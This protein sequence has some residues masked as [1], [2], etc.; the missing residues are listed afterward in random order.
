MSRTSSILP[1]SIERKS[2]RGD[3]PPGADEAAPGR[4]QKPR[5]EHRRGTSNRRSAGFYAQLSRKPVDGVRAFIPSPAQGVVSWSKARITTSGEWV[6]S[7]RWIAMRAPGGS[8]DRER[9]DAPGDS[10]G[11]N[12]ELGQILSAIAEE[13]GRHCAAVCDGINADFAARAAHA[14]KALPRSQVA[15]ALQALKQARQA[16]LA[17]AR[18]TARTELQGRKQTAITLYTRRRRRSIKG[19]PVPWGGPPRQGPN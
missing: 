5:A 18:Q 7:A 17:L 16:A 3:R 14:R 10:G 13:V 8:G 19:G 2:E 9:P 4:L 11:D 12:L 1:T 6:G 15:G